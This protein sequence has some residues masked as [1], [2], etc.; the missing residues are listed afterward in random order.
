MET[1]VVNIQ[2]GEGILWGAFTDKNVMINVVKNK[3]MEYTLPEGESE[4]T[5]TT[6]PRL[7]EGA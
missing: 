3:L 1:Y 2:T 5:S 4:F 7:C 6:I